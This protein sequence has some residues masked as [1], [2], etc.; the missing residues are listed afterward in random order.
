[1]GGVPSPQGQALEMGIELLVTRGRDALDH[2]R[3]RNIKAARIRS[4]NVPI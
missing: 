2:R 3:L 1:M 4:S